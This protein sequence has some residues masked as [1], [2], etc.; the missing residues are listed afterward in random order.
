MLEGQPQELLSAS[1]EGSLYPMAG[2]GCW[3]HQGDPPDRPLGVGMVGGGGGSGCDQGWGDCWAGLGGLVGTGWPV[4][5][6]E[7]RRGILRQTRK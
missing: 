1:G 5:S 7:V 3:E 2:W 4:P 6:E